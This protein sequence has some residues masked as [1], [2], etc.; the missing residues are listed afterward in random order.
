MVP[1]S[2]R[3]PFL[4]LPESTTMAS[5]STAS[6]KT[7]YRGLFDGPGTIVFFVATILGRVPISMRSLGVV[8]LIEQ[9]TG[10]FGLAGIIGAT[11]TFV[12]AFALPR[13]GRLVDRIGERT[14]LIWTTTVHAIGMTWLI[15]AA[16]LKPNMLLMMIGAAL[17]GASSMPFGSLSRARW[18]GTL[19][20][21][22]RLG[23]AYAMESMADEIGF[24]VGPMLVV[25]LSISITPGAGLI[26]SLTMTLLASTVLV[27]QKR[28]ET[29][30]RVAP[31]PATTS[32]ST[33]VIG[34]PGVQVLV[35]SL[36]FIGVIFGAVDIVMVAFADHLGRPNM[37]SILTSIFAVGSFIG[38]IAYGAKTWHTSVDR[39]YRLAIWW[40]S[41]GTIPILLANTVFTMSLAALLTGVAIAPAMIS[42][43]TVIENLAPPKMLTEAFAWLSSAVATGAAMGV[44][45]AGQVLDHIGVRGGQAI[46][47]FGGILTSLVVLIWAKYLRAERSADNPE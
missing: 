16:Y 22:P 33:S 21:G 14:L 10:S 11:Q 36:F 40:L 38:A 31:Q 1:R 3:A 35:A 43:N 19:G 30:T 27:L 25:P 41:L 32:E 12:A 44:V 23:K 37:A 13:L 5:T 15:T 20:K 17:V 4:Y 42:A 29:N 8:L 46:G 45:I 18:V 47:L 39:R 7:T 24:I 34:I 28:P 2:A 26:G 6:T 9:L